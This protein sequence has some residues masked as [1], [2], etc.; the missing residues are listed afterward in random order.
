MIEIRGGRDT[1][2]SVRVRAV[3]VPMLKPHRTAS[4]VVTSAPLVLLDLKTSSG[5]VGRAYVFT[6][7]TIA[8][9]S[10]ARLVTDLM[11]V[12]HGLPLA[13]RDISGVLQSR[14]RLLGPQGFAGIAMALIDMAAWDALAVTH[15]EPL[16]RLL[17]AAPRAVPA[18][19]S[20]GMSDMDTAAY[21]AHEAMDSGFGGV[22][23]KICGS[24]AAADHRLVG[25]YVNALGPEIDI[26]VDYNQSLSRAEAIRRGKV[27]EEYNLLWIEEP[28]RA[29][30]DDSHAEIA[31]VLDTPIQLGENWWGPHDCARSLAANACDEVMLDVMKIGGVTGWLAAAALAEPTGRR[32]SSHIFP[33]FSAHL[34]CATPTARYLEWLD[35]VS[36]ILRDPVLPVDGM[37]TPREVPGVGLDWDEPAICR[38]EVA[39]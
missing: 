20:T 21:E 35:L 22:K 7:S 18:Y 4:G 33:E 1:V 31:R 12:V 26:M 3:D 19:Q 11:P 2:A 9:A 13:P 34:L 38:Y 39:F 28:C 8:L 36:P 5:A 15:D 16:C 37:Y 14:F 6:Y 32:I 25:A 29:D 23:F 27:L 30:D 10:I 24:S 17:G